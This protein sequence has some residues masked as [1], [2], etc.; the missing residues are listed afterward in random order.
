MAKYQ[1]KAKRK[2][3]KKGAALAYTLIATMVLMIL[4]TSLFTAAGYNIS[5][6]TKN[7]NARQSYITCKSAVEYAKSHILQQATIAK[8]LNADREN[9][10]PTDQTQAA[11]TCNNN[12]KPAMAGFYV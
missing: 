1:K 10:F 3:N 2:W 5:L 12:I 7:D 9:S 11:A 4:S 6:T 8:N